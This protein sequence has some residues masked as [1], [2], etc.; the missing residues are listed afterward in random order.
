MKTYKQGKVELDAELKRLNK[1]IKDAK[2][3]ITFD[4]HCPQCDKTKKT[5][6]T[7]RQ[8]TRCS[9]LQVYCNTE[10]VS[11]AGQAR[12]ECRGHRYWLHNSCSKLRMTPLSCV[13]P[14]HTVTL[15]HCRTVALSHWHNR[16]GMGKTDSCTAAPGTEGN[17]FPTRGGVY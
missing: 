5:N 12:T 15:S 7:R 9:S 2:Q 10:T 4:F 3:N 1:A 6:K 14:L 17:P 16:V 8:L 13:L 11:W